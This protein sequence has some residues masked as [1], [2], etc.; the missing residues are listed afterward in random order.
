MKHYNLLIVAALAGLS[1]SSCAQK[2]A[3]GTDP[4]RR[5][6]RFTSNLSAYA[7]KAT[8]TNFE[9]GDEV[10]LF[11]H[12]NG[13][14]F[15]DNVKMTFVGNELVPEHDV[16]WSENQPDSVCTAFF[17]V[18][19]YR[20]DWELMA[21]LAVFSV[22]ADQSTRE[23]YAASDLLAASY[24][25]YPD[26]ETVPLNFTHRLCKFSV[27]ISDADSVSRVYLS[28]VYGKSRLVVN[29]AM[30]VR[31]VG[32]KGDISMYA[33]EG[34]ASETP[35]S[36]IIPPQ[37][38]DFKVVVELKD[39]KQYAFAPSSWN[40]VT[41]LQSAYEYNTWVSLDDA[42]E[43]DYYVQVRDWTADNDSQFGEYVSDRYHTEGLW[44]L[45]TN[46][47]DMSYMEKDNGLTDW[48]TNYV[49]TPDPSATY[50]L[51]YRIASHEYVYGLPEEG[52]VVIP[53][54]TLSLVEGGKPF[55]INANADC[56]VSFNPYDNTLRTAVYDEKIYLVSFSDAV[57]YEMSRTEAG[58]YTVDFDYWGENFYFTGSSGWTLGSVGYMYYPGVWQLYTS[59]R[60]FCR[61][62]SSGKYRISLNVNNLRLKIE[63]LGEYVPAA[64]TALLGD[65]TYAKD[66][67]T[68]FDISIKS[69]GYGFGVTMDGRDF[70]ANYDNARSRMVIPFQKVREWYWSDY[71]ANVQDWLC[72]GVGEGNASLGY[73]GE[74]LMYCTVSEDGSSIE[75]TPAPKDNPTNFYCLVASLRDGPYAGYYA[76]YWKMPLPQVWSKK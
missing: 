50:D 56:I 70:Y 18:Y 72:A 41:V 23:R 48:F 11:A 13:Y 6:I 17:A 46:G 10:S 31:A 43:A 21:D 71:S 66:D 30:P 63:S 47:S 36:A 75:V 45:R 29:H 27:Y 67:G 61:I 57:R 5:A 74:D 1:L 4:V 59:G 32:E 15:S 51:V 24:I 54:D 20:E 73:E 7:T 44:Y 58:I 3:I 22:N 38:M 35:W 62:E 76:E 8:D 55:R 60:Y 64:Y 65:W 42:S 26:C 19:P 9:A 2:E 33:V 69:S 28:D 39:G 52:A 25:A 37:E 40:D 49:F 12:T 53:C 16:C 34:G 14:L 68:V